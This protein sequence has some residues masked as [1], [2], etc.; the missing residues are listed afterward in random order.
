MLINFVPTFVSL[1]NMKI[2]A[3]KQT[4][5]NTAVGGFFKCQCQGEKKCTYG[6]SICL[7]NTKNRKCILHFMQ[8]SI[9][10]LWNDKH[11]ISI[12]VKD[13]IFFDSTFTSKCTFKFDRY[14]YISASEPISIAIF[15]LILS[16]IWIS[17]GWP[18]IFAF[19]WLSASLIYLHTN[20][21]LPS[22][23][24]DCKCT[25]NWQQAHIAIVI[26]TCKN[27]IKQFRKCISIGCLYF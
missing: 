26:I 16:W 23:A 8:I 21:H 10:W 15:G 11:T 5:L 7:N 25:I 17:I 22:G 18:L 2:Q 24:L 6:K 13:E 3:Q 14:L 1:G 4:Y 20:M 9:I 12:N 27:T 19:S